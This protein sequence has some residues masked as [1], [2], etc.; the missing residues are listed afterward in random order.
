[1][2]VIADDSAVVINLR[3]Y[4]AAARKVPARGDVESEPIEQS[5]QSIHLSIRV[6]CE[7]DLGHPSGVDQFLKMET[8]ELALLGRPIRSGLLGSGKHAV[9]VARTP[10]SRHRES[11]RGGELDSAA[12]SGG[13]RLLSHSNAQA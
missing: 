5:A 6:G 12:H 9:Y 10:R 4:F 11:G 1:M 3:K 2:L 13:L 7:P 8:P